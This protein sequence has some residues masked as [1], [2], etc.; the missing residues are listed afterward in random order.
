MAVEIQEMV[1]R[2]ASLNAQR[3]Q[4]EKL[5]KELKAQEDEVK[6]SI[7]LEMA[8]SGIQSVHLEGLGRVVKTM[9]NHYEITDINS[10]ALQMFRHMI[11]CAKNGRQLSD[12]LLLQGRV[13]REA[14]E[15]LLPDDA[16]DADMA[17]FGVKKAEE[18]VLSIR[19]S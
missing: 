6:R 14:L 15:A 1:Q 19:K 18:P 2:Y 17:A 4:Y 7:L 3:M 11:Y 13:S 16:T 9:R 5:A 10:L 8:A 12:A